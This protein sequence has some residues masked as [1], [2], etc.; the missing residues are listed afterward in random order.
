MTIFF[1]YHLL[2]SL[3]V[4]FF[5]LRSYFHLG[6]FTLSRGKNIFFFQLKH[7]PSI[8]IEILFLQRL[9]LYKISIG[10]LI[11]LYSVLLLL[12]YHYVN[13]ICLY[14][15]QSYPIGQVFP[16]CSLP[17]RV[18]QLHLALCISWFLIAM[19]CQTKFPSI[20]GLVRDFFFFNHK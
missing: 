6:L 12:F 10:L 18:S 3:L 11:L 19:F 8:I 15:S 14:Y 7:F 20:P 1:L 4:C 5:P 17:L 16:T 13:I 2:K 9:S